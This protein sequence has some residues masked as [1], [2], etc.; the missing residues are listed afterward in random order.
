M[1]IIDKTGFDGSLAA[2]QVLPI[3]FDVINDEEDNYHLKRIIATAITHANI[4]T[5]NA[6]AE[7]IQKHLWQRDEKFAQSCLYGA[8]EHSRLQ[9]SYFKQQRQTYLQAYSEKPIQ[10]TN[11][12]LPENWKN[13]LREQIARGQ[14]V[15]NITDIDLTTHSVWYLLLVIL[16]IPNGSNQ[17]EHIAVFSHIITLLI[18]AEK[19]SNDRDQ[20]HSWHE[21]IP[22]ELIG[23]FSER[24]ANY[25]FSIPEEDAKQILDIILTRIEDGVDLASKVLL[26]LSCIAEQQKNFERYWL[27]WSWFAKILLPYATEPKALYKYRSYYSYDSDI[28]RRLLFLNVPWQGVDVEIQMFQLGVKPITEFVRNVGTNPVVYSAII[29]LIYY[30][31]Q[32]FKPIE[33]IEDLVNFQKQTELNL[34]ADSNI[35]FCLERIF[36]RLLV[37]NREPKPLSKNSRAACLKLLDAMVETS[38]SQA[39]FLREHLLQLK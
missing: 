27:F 24:L 5:C 36:H 15:L 17:S 29:R 14:C 32:L 37:Q 30:F 31:P 22:Y 13:K 19:S 35:V 38:S 12:K 28:I 6:A 23:D 4:T 20:E 9:E 18:E 7:G 39:Y 2:A 25:L 10:S 21:K 34:L 8:I 16:I 11:L 1:R 26:Y 3:I 33:L